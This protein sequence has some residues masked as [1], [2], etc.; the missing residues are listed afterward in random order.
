VRS[1]LL[2]AFLLL[3]GTAPSRAVII[4]TFT[5]DSDF[6]STVIV[7]P[8]NTVT[9][10]S[11]GA[12]PN[13]T[14]IDTAPSVS[15]GPLTVSASSDQ[16]FGDGA[17]LSTSIERTDLI[18]SFRNPILAFGLFPF[19][20]DAAL[21]PIS[22]EL[23]LT[24]V[25]S[26]SASFAVSNTGLSFVGYL[27]N[28]PFSSVRISINS[29]DGNVSSVGFNTLSQEVLIGIPVGT[30]ANIPEPATL[31]LFAPGLIMLAGFGV[32]FRLN[33]AGLGRSE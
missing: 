33:I 4:E 3:A 13:I 22:G 30:S 6:L 15:A 11:G 9:I 17:L 29:F 18:L 26:G 31:Y 10:G 32:S 2:S 23:E 7:P 25:G 28:T 1:V 12:S 8:G 14:L 24:L 20:T 21:N 19:I 5:N 27:S 16:L